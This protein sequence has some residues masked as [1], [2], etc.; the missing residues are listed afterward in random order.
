MLEKKVLTSVLLAFVFA[1]SVFTVSAFASPTDGWQ[2]D[3]GQIFFYR[4]GAKVK[5]IQNVPMVKE[6]WPAQW[7]EMP[8]NVYYLFDE[9]TGA[10]DGSNEGWTE[11]GDKYYYFVS[12]TGMLFDGWHWCEDY[13]TMHYMMPHAATGKLQLTTN[14]PI[15]WLTYDTE[16]VT[17]RWFN[18][19]ATGKGAVQQELDGWHDGVFFFGYGVTQGWGYDDGY[20]HYF[21]ENPELTLGLVQDLANPWTDPMDF[22]FGDTGKIPVTSNVA[23]EDHFDYAV[24]SFLPGITF[25]I[26]ESPSVT[27]AS[28]PFNVVGRAGAVVRS[29]PVRG[30]YPQAG[31]GWRIALEGAFKPEEVTLQIVG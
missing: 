4:D 9:V 26:I 14:I 20:L 17:H 6:W 24:E 2:F 15:D 28:K 8:E 29:V 16:R 31:G 21:G 30:L 19:D 3:D 13:L 5:G 18:F 11:I 10:V 25:V 27:I 1:L 23:L 22:D 7:G 12:N